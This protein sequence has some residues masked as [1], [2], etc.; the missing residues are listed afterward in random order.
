L[1]ADRDNNRLPTTPISASAQRDHHANRLKEVVATT[2]V[3]NI[4]GLKG[5]DSCI[6]AAD[7]LASSSV[8]SGRGVDDLTGMVDCSVLV[9]PDGELLIVPQKQNNVTVEEDERGEPKVQR[10][11]TSLSWNPE[12]QSNDL[13]EEYCSAVFLGNDLPNQG[14]RAMNGFSSKG[15]SMAAQSLALK[16]SADS[17]AELTEFLEELV[18]AKTSTTIREKKMIYKMRSMVGVTQLELQASKVDEYHQYL[19]DHFTAESREKYRNFGIKRIINPKNQQENID[20]IDISPDRVGPLNYSD[21]TILATIKALED[22]YSS[23]NKSESKRLRNMSERT[24]ILTKLRNATKKSE[25]RV[26]CRQVA[27]QK[28]MRR[29]K[30]L[31]DYLRECKEDAKAKW[32][33]VHETEKLVTKLV[34]EKMMDR[35]RVMEEERKKKAEEDEVQLTIS[36]EGKSGASASEIWDIVSA[37]T[38]SIEEGSF[39]PVANISHD[40]LSTATDNESRDEPNEFLPPEDMEFEMDSRYEFEVQYRLP[41]L[42]ILALA[43]DQAVEDAATSLLSVL[44]DWDTTYRSAQVAA[45]TCLVSSGNAQASCLRS[46]VAIE[47]KSIEERLKLLEKLERVANNIDVRADLDQYINVDMARKGGQ[48]YRGEHD[49]GGVASALKHLHGDDGLEANGDIEEKYCDN[50]DKIDEST[51]NCSSMSSQNIEERLEC[52]F[53][54]DPLL[55]DNTPQNEAL[56]EFE[57]NVMKLCTIAMGK[58][59]QHA[60]RRSTI[61]YA[62]NAKRSTNAQ[63]PSTTQ[64]DG[65]C[66]IFNAVLSGCDIKDNG[67]ISSAI[68]L[69]GLSDHFYVQQSSKKVYIKSHLVGHHLWD[70]NEF[71][72]RAL[73]EI[74]AEKLS[75]SCVL[76]TFERNS[77]KA[78]TAERKE[79]SEWTVTYKTRWHDLTKVERY[80]AASRVNAVVFAQA[81]AMADSMFKLCGCQEKT[82]AFI[83]RACVKNQLPISQRT[84]LLRQINESKS[85]R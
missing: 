41:E 45:E 5:F 15:W 76:S 72:D 36:D 38:A 48:S 59:H 77:T 27:L 71:W 63:I 82:S 9:S 28:T 2:V 13:G 42:R 39:E 68:L 40:S 52:F 8:P 69:M 44:S 81:S 84:A 47:R 37:A 66:R 1:P 33:E 32:D 54:S 43:A 22:Y 16:Q 67:G 57:A 7:A 3:D 20:V 17:M 50:D 31:E 30:T 61:C 56:E 19:R 60:T 74:I 78:M 55:V 18:L 14:D 25:D 80:K 58:S 11:R 65:L 21:G 35:N 34:E 6:E 64:F 10:I 46:I 85:N 79:R 62:M 23:L 73:Q 83:R 29:I 4:D 70:E 26:R 49:D 75:Y 53:R 24:G 12:I 51:D